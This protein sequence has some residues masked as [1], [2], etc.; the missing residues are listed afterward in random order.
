MDTSD[1][2]EHALELTGLT[3]PF[4][5]GA[6]SPEASISDNAG[7]SMLTLLFKSLSSMNAEFCKTTFWSRLNTMILPL[8]LLLKLHSPEKVFCR[9]FS[10]KMKNFGWIEWF[11]SVPAWRL[12]RA[13]SPTHCPPHTAPSSPPWPVQRLRRRLRTSRNWRFSSIGIEP[14]TYLGSRSR[15]DNETQ[16]NPSIAQHLQPR[17]R[18]LRR[19]RECDSSPNAQRP[20][21]RDWNVS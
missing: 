1:N 18:F 21:L 15:F 8:P 20:R 19:N 17:K 9:L 7:P 2:S 3:E 16:P 6:S 13:I 12:T 10:L 11:S 14:R 4:S 5:C